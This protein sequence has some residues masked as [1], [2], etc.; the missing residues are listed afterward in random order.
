MKPQRTILALMAAVGVIGAN[1]LMLSPIAGAIGGSLG[2]DPARVLLAAAVYGLST[3]LAALLLAPLVDRFGADRALRIALVAL[4]AGFAGSA[5]APILPVFWMAQGIAGLATG[6]AL[7]AAYALAALAAPPGQAARVMGQV[8][9]GWTLSLVAGVTLAALLT[10]LIGWRM[11]YG[12]MGL[13]T[14]GVL[15]GLQ[16]LPSAPRGSATSPLSALRVPGIG[17]ALAAMG[18]LMLAFY[19]S[20]TYLGAQVTETLGRSTAAAGLVAL[21]YGVGF[22]ASTLLDPLLDRLGPRKAGVPLFALTILLYLA[23]AAASGDYT[24]LLLVAFVWG[25]TQHLGLNLCVGRLVALDPAQR[26]AILGLNSA[27]TYLAVFGGASLGGVVFATWGFA[28]IPILSAALLAAVTL[29]RAR[30]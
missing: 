14:L 21:S 8:L 22:G 13:A 3:A 18:A 23:M 7:P 12:G 30:R 16:G 25:I 20:Y 29:E 10:D 2:A 28:T 6:V 24:A 17:R 5:L 26:G 9:S 1:G 11:V 4:A 19:L 27:I 15:V